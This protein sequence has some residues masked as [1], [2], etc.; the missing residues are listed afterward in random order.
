MK[1][2]EFRWMD[3]DIQTKL[4]ELENNKN[5]INGFSYINPP[6]PKH[7]NTKK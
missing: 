6:P 2:N 4:G 7:T 5:K 1:V 3:A